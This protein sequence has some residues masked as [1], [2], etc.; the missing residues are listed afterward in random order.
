M[1]SFEP[2]TLHFTIT[3]DQLATILRLVE[4]AGWHLNYDIIEH[5]ASKGVVWLWAHH[6]NHG[7]RFPVRHWIEVDGKVILSEDVDWDWDA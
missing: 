4:E 5:D 1:I 6:E 3:N 2:N 7:G